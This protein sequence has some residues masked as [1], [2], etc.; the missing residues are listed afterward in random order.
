VFDRRTATHSHLLDGPRVRAGS[1][2]PCIM[3]TFPPSLIDLLALESRSDALMLWCRRASMLDEDDVRRHGIAWEAA[4]DF[5]APSIETAFAALALA[6][7]AFI[8]AGDPSAIDATTLDVVALAA[9]RVAELDHVSVGECRAA[10]AVVAGLASGRLASRFDDPRLRSLARRL[11]MAMFTKLLD[12]EFPDVDPFQGLAATMSSGTTWTVVDRMVLDDLAL[13][14]A[15][16]PVE[17]ERKAVDARSRI[18][19]LG[20]I[21]LGGDRDTRLVLERFKDVLEHPLPFVTPTPGAILRA[22][23]ILDREMPNFADATAA[24]IGDLRLAASL[25]APARIRPTLLLGPP[26]A[27]KSRWT[28]RV[29]ELLGLPARTL[30]LA[31]VSD[32]RHLCG[33]ARGWSS[34]Q[35]SGVVDAVVTSKVANVLVVGDELDKAGGSDRLGRVDQALLGLLERETASNWFDECLRAPVDLGSVNWLFTANDVARLPPPLLD[36]LRIVRVGP[37]PVDAFAAVLGTILDDIA[38]EFG[39]DR[40]F[41]PALPRHA[42][43]ALRELWSVSRSP[44]RL[45]AAVLC[46]LDGLTADAMRMVH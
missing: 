45:K 26:G 10:C 32:A 6:R 1:L 41:F 39:V 38:V 5:H 18:L 8:A 24:I 21:A 22:Q 9:A 19:L 16:V 43:D 14:A 17:P 7:S 44:R 42:I 11:S 40:T 34:A 15:S 3:D 23:S 25:G 33:T 13:R 4:V 27:G 35:P 36:R 2:G 31:G 20:T 37:L 29:S 28:R 30:S 12:T 46:V